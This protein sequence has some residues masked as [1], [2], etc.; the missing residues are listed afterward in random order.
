MQ[1][2]KQESRSAAHR[3]RDPRR[4][5]PGLWKDMFQALLPRTESRVSLRSTG[6]LQPEGLNSW[7]QA[8]RKELC[9]ATTARQCFSKPSAMLQMGQEAVGTGT[10]P[11]VAVQPQGSL[12][13]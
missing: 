5:L 3:F 1:P 8:A 2:E 7:E 12:S 10:A 4:L 6:S 9:S 13:V 11:A